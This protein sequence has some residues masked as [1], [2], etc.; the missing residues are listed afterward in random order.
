MN[1][2]S[3]P[4]DL[5]TNDYNTSPHKA[6]GVLHLHGEGNIAYYECTGPF[7]L[8]AIKAL[9]AARIAL[10]KKWQP[11]G[12]IAAI[13]HWKGSVL[14]TSD[15]M[16]AYSAGLSRFVEEE[17]DL[18]AVA[19]VADEEIE[20]MAF[21]LP[22]FSKIFANTQTSFQLFTTMTE[23]QNWVQGLLDNTHT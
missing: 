23:A 5:S 20:G 11:V 8:E 10:M 17:A 7:N 14:M 15:A 1:K 9:G 6:H 13:V 4:V 2:S 18:A 19:W 12:P 21:M 16:A 22:R 3:A